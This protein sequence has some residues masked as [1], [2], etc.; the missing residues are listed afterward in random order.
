V[1]QRVI[2]TLTPAEPHGLQGYIHFAILLGLNLFGFGVTAR[3]EDGT[4]LFDGRVVS[5]LSNTSPYKP[6]LEATIDAKHLISCASSRA[7]DVPVE[8]AGTFST[9]PNLP[10]QGDLC[11]KCGEFGLHPWNSLIETARLCQACGMIEERYAGK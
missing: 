1:T 10:H 6:Y 4:L 7:M 9:R 2:L 11:N 5:S 8:S 3:A